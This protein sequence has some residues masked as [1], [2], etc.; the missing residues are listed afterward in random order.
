MLALP[1]HLRSR[2]I[3]ALE[4]Q[5]L[6][7]PYPIGSLQTVLGGEWDEV[8]SLQRELQRLEARGI[9]G[10]SIAFALE[11]AR[12][13]AANVDRPAL[14]WSGPGDRRLQ[15]R[16]TRVVYDELVNEAEERI[17]VSTYV[18]HGGSRLFKT[19]A[20]RMDAVPG[21]EVTLLM[22]VERPYGS[23][24]V[25]EELVA[26]FTHRLWT[27]QW[28]GER[29]PDVYYDPRSLEIPKPDGVL[30][31]KALVVD[32]RAC[33]VGSANLTEAAFERNFEAGVL[34]RDRGLAS[35]IA[36]HFRMLVEHDR[37]ERLVGS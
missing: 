35:S 5:R 12:V 4:T 18:V 14:V 6:E 3:K 13:E 15:S 8:E 33:F 20:A 34:S 28:P 24:T 36:R 37:V 32:E 26:K 1:S 23:T 30:H 29:R 7:P 11:L 31:A 10:K 16:R 17:W 2:L 9:G 25:A 19:L 21:L 27:Q 22:N